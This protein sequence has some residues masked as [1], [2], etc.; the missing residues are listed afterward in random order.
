M[1]VGK[2]DKK[3]SVVEVKCSFSNEL[4]AKTFTESLVNNVTTFYIKTK[5]GRSQKSVAVLQKKADSLRTALDNALYAR[6]RSVDQTPDLNP[7]RQVATVG[8][9]KKQVDIQV[10]ST[11]YGE[12]LKNL[13]LSKITLSREAPFIQ[14]IDKPILPLDEVRIGSVKGCLIGCVIVVFLTVIILVGR[15]AIHSLMK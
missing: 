3:L 11:A 4:F 12:V 6:A 9:Q 5:T 8:G 10:L 7:V 2:I 1:S 13:E 15:R 14:I